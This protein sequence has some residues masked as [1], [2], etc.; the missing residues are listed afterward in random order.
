V[1]IVLAFVYLTKNQQLYDLGEMDPAPPLRY[2]TVTTR[3]EISFD[4]VA[5]LTDS[6]ASTVRD[7]NPALLRSATPPAEYEL[8]LPEGTGGQFR[9]EIAL[10]PEDKRGNWRRHTVEQG[11]TLAAVARRY[12]INESEIAELNDLEGEALTSGVRLTIPTQTRL[13]H[14]GGWGQAGGFVEG[15]SGRYRIANGDTLGGIAQ[16]FG[17]SIGQL[18][19]WNG[20]PNS[21]IR[22]GRYLVIQSSNR[23]SG[24]VSAA[25]ASSP[26]QGTGPAPS[27]SYTVRRGDN[28]SVIATR[29]RVSVSDLQAWN[30]L[31]SSRIQ[32]GQVLK[33]PGSGSQQSAAAPAGGQYRIRNGDNLATIASRFGVSVR[34][35]Q[36]WNGLRGTRIRAGDTLRVAAVSQQSA[37]PQQRA[38]AP[39][40]SSPVVAASTVQAAVSSPPGGERY[41]IRRGD[42]LESI[43]QRFNV[44]VGQLRAW[45]ALRGSRITAGEDLQVGPAGGRR[46]PG[47][48]V[49]A[50][51]APAASAPSVAGSARA[52]AQ[53]YRIR[54]GDNLAEI[55]RRFS[56]SIQDLMAWNS[57]TDHRITAGE[58]LT[59]QANSSPPAGRYRIRRG[60]T[61]DSIAKRFGVSIDDLK[62]WNDLRGSRIHEGNYLTV[63]PEA[64]ANQGQPRLASAG[65]L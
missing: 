44:S 59:I 49:A 45:N 63:R 15:G 37:P 56:V 24:S 48:A 8:R 39:A 38:A 29:H 18:M 62:S 60:D 13:E 21:R 50:A 53:R 25:S 41:R 36:A 11:E 32:V 28:L 10:I 58:S 51:T 27:G 12:R 5:D 43:A 65:G 35:L 61:L 47:T 31:R 14:Y 34:D 6:T 26:R 52:T 20:L 30:G 54:R 7:L 57:L 23:S 9:E 33:V 55:A 4:L 19:A 16:R 2:D 17:V 46:V 40:V 3:S 64:T 1:P 42:N 22:A